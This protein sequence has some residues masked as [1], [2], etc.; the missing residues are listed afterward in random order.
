MNLGTLLVAIL[1]LA[2]VGVL[3]A[4][5]VLMSFGGKTNAKYGNR[6]MVARVSLQGLALLV[7][8]LLFAVGGK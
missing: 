3:I 2:V 1:M 6:L 5:V 8:F 4:G 7:L